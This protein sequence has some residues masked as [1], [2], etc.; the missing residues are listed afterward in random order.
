MSSFSLENI[1]RRSD[2]RLSV[3]SVRRLSDLTCISTT[4]GK[5]TCKSAIINSVP[6]KSYG[7]TFA[8]LSPRIL[9]YP[10]GSNIVLRDL[11]SQLN[12]TE[13]KSHYKTVNDVVFLPGRHELLSIGDE[14]IVLN[15]VPSSINEAKSDAATLQTDNWS[16]SD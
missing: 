16:D 7:S 9:C 14:G 15:W 3:F 12:L 4:P 5:T 8:L 10:D 11:K 6:L 13:L 2:K 1:Q